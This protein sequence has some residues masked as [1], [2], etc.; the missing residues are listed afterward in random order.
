MRCRSRWIAMILLAVPAVI[1]GV[2]PGAAQTL[3]KADRILVLKAKRQLQLLRGEVVLKSYPIALGR[4]PKGPKR[5]EGDGRT[6]EGLYF[7]DG[8]FTDTAYHLA[9]HISYPSELDRARARKAGRQVGSHILIHGMPDRFGRT[10]PVRF[11]RDWTNGCIAVGNIAIEE[12]WNAVDDG[13]AIE[14]RP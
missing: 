7:I 10:D 8:H 9:L 4:H 11:F 12:I 14:I 1:G 13:T 2:M 3:D 5:R 6:P